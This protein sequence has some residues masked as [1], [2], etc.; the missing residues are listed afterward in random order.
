MK[1]YLIDKSLYKSYSDCKVIEDIDSY[2]ES[3]IL[4][5]CKPEEIIYDKLSQENIIILQQYGCILR[6]HEDKKMEITSVFNTTNTSVEQN[7]SL[8]KLNTDIKV[9]TESTTQPPKMKLLKAGEGKKRPPIFNLF[10]KKEEVEVEDVLLDDNLYS[11]LNN[12]SSDLLKKDNFK[13]YLLNNNYITNEEMV[14]ILKEIDK[15]KSRGEDPKFIEMARKM[16]I[17]TEEESA[18]ILSNVTKKEVIP[19]SKL[20]INKLKSLNKELRDV[21]KSF[22]I[23]DFNAKKET[24]TI[25][26][27]LSQNTIEYNVLE[28]D[29]LGYR[30]IVL[31]VVDGVIEELKSQNGMWYTWIQV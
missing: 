3:L 27:D 28:K 25:I 2:I 4:E 22:F 1:A 13:D 18:E 12:Q 7:K 15:K 21:K 11:L 31:N 16:K 17:I 23:V 5:E 9:K 24:I 8:K 19:K 6:K 30:I 29:Y 20:D 14:E 26:K 10:S